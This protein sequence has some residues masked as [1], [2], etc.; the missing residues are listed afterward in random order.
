M[1]TIS[2]MLTT[3]ENHSDDTLAGNDM[4]RLPRRLSSTPLI[5]SPE[6]AWRMRRYGVLPNDAVFTSVCLTMLCSQA[7]RNNTRHVSTRS[8]R[9]VCVVR[10]RFRHLHAGYTIA[11]GG[12]RMPSFRM[13]T[14][15]IQ[16]TSVTEASAF[17]LT[18]D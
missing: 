15:T 3:L 18:F 11:T 16:P 17:V 7:Y 8:T 4:S 9:S 6:T 12:S 13:A 1:W 2:R 5:S 14:D 10:I